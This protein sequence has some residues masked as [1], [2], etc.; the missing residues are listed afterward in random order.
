[1]YRIIFS[2]GVR[3]VHSVELMLMRGGE[4][5]H[6]IARKIPD[7]GCYHWNVPRRVR[8]SNRYKDGVWLRGSTE[9][10]SDYEKRL[11]MQVPSD[12]GI[13]CL[14]VMSMH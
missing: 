8:Q 7:A 9:I 13:L 2:S 12:W 11:E 4:E 3:K 5:C 14:S 6:L 1:M 10:N